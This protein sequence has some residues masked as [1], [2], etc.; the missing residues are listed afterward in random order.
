MPLDAFLE[1][2]RGGKFLIGEVQDA[3]FEGK[4][5]EIAS[6]QLGTPASDSSLPGSEDSAEEDLDVSGLFGE[7]SGRRRPRKKKEEPVTVAAPAKDPVLS[8]LEKYTFTITKDTDS[9]SPE[10]F[11]SY[12]ETAAL[13]HKPFDV[14]ILTIRKLTGGDP[15]CFLKMTFSEVYVMSYTMQVGSSKVDAIPD[16]TIT[17]CFASC[18]F[19]YR[20]QEAGGKLGSPITRQWDFTKPR[21]PG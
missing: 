7:K 2:K 14:A 15:L 5:I 20:P 21:S 9:S 6:F 1:L 12:C 18:K 10:L 16:E 17:F 19:E 11:L 3:A 13:R 8:A 4:A